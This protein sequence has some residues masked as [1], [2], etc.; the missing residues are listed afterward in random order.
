MANINSLPYF[1]INNTK[2]TNIIA[3]F[4][5]KKSKN[6]FKKKCPIIIL[7]LP[8]KIK[9]KIYSAIKQKYKYFLK[10]DVENI[11]LL[12]NHKILLDN[13]LMFG[14]STSKHFNF[15]TR[16]MKHYLKYEIPAFL[17]Q[18]SIKDR[19]LP[20][21]NLFKLDFSWIISFVFGI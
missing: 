21:G 7:F 18:S 20:L 9:I 11:I 8:D 10:L 3:R 17:K 16:K 12:I 14:D 15:M 6:Y 19:G 13:L 2:E 5:L 4:L 1:Q